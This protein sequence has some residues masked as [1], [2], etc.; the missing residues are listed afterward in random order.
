[1]LKSH[2]PRLARVYGPQQ[3][4][5]PA[6]MEIAVFADA[7]RLLSVPTTLQKAEVVLATCEASALQPVADN[8]IVA[9][10]RKHIEKCFV[11]SLY[12]KFNANGF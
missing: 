7:N 5:S 3:R 4:P 9:Q 6:L 10:V 11:S 12:C 1:M 8:M 2:C